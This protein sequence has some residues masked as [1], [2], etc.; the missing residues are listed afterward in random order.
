MA[1]LRL[2]QRMEVV[3]HDYEG[4]EH[5][6]LAIEVAQRIAHDPGDLR[7]AQQARTVAAIKPFFVAVQKA[8]LVLLLR[9][10]IP[11]RRM[12]LEPVLLFFAPF[13]E[14]RLRHGIARG[15]R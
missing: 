4:I 6:T 14:E 7:I 10:P 13:A 1:G 12:L 11:R 5:I 8:S 2:D 15:E 9:F 3:W